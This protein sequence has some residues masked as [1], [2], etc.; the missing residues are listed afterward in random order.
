MKLVELDRF[1]D[2]HQAQAD[3]DERNSS[4]EGSAGDDDFDWEDD[5]PNDEE[6]NDGEEA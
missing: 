5:Q 6:N 3:L 1:R 4:E 2:V